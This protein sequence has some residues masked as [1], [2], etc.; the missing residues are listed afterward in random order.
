MYEDTNLFV[1]KCLYIVPSQCHRARGAAVAH[2]CIGYVPILLHNEDKH[3]A[4]HGPD[5]GSCWMWTIE[6]ETL[7]EVL[8]TQSRPLLPKFYF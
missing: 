8:Q 3:G 5:P 4:Q 7:V 2:S 6:L 1:S